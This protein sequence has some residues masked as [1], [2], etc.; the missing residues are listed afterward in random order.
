MYPIEQPILLSEKLGLYFDNPRHEHEIEIIKKYIKVSLDSPNK[1]YEYNPALRLPISAP[2]HILSIKQAFSKFKTINKNDKYKGQFILENKKKHIFEVLAKMWVV[3]RYNDY[4]E[5]NSLK[6]ARED[7]GG[8]WVVFLGE[9]NPI[10]ASEK[11]ANSF[12]HLLSL[13]ISPKE[14]YFGQC[15]LLHEGHY[16]LAEPKIDRW[17]NKAILSWAFFCY[18]TNKDKIDENQWLFDFSLVKAQAIE[19]AKSID[20]I[21]DEKSKEKLLYVGSMLRL[22]GVEIRDPKMKLVT[23]VSII[24]LMLTHAPDF[25]RFN[26][27]DSISKQFKLKLGVLLYQEDCGINFLELN[28]RLGEIYSQR[29]NVAHGNFAEYEKIIKKEVDKIKE[30]DDWDDWKGIARENFVSD[31]YTYIK[32]IMKAYLKDRNFVDFL[33]DS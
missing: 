10:V 8:N 30:K 11:S 15:L 16:D 23:L 29:S 17:L 19:V 13:L 26:V 14:D 20:E 18:Q 32:V 7:D 4:G 9:D 2:R 5:F 6:K 33:K 27:E 22:C 24:E 3:L 25:K 31:C 21:L 1:M 12:A 28:K